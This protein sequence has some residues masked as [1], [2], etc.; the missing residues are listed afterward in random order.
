M[1]DYYSWVTQEMFDE[2]LMDILEHDTCVGELLSIPGIYEILAEEY[3]NEVLKQLTQERE[4]NKC[5]G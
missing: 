3:N 1:T 2:K 4:A 5:I